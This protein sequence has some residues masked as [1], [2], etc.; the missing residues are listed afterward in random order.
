MNPA[1]NFLLWCSENRW[2]QTNIPQ[3]AFVQ[4]AV[5]RFMP[6]E[7]L[8][9]AVREAEIFSTQNIG[10]VFTHLGESILIRSEADA[11][12][13]H[14]LQVLRTIAEKNIPTEISLKLTQIGIDLDYKI[15][16]EN[17]Q[18][19]IKLANELNITVWID[20]EQ[21]LYVNTTIKFYKYFKENF[22]N[23]GLCLQ[24]YLLR[25][26][27]DF[28]SL[29]S[30]SPFIR[31]VKGAY[32]ESAD[33]AFKKKSDTDSNYFLIA[34]KM[35][36]NLNDDQNSRHAFGTH[37]TRLIQ[38]IMDYAKEKNLPSE[39]LE[40][41]MLYGIKTSE[42]QRIA[43]LGYK[44]KVLISYGTHWYPWYVRRLAE[45]PANVWFVLKNLFVR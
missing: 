32:N 17:F 22:K 27:K 30:I 29:K 25:T 34:K 26:Q 21:S 20:I 19:I 11:V 13:D 23:V 45:R 28:D 37:D 15:G 39:K 7:N 44:L 9:D 16:V 18:K 36:N 3:L 10:T 12:T 2:M 35:I 14:Y 43:K 41:Q 40:F 6:G 5:R 42:Q 24:S 4:Q 31:L 38:M 33:V 1:R 8:E